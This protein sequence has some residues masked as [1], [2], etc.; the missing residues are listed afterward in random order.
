MSVIEVKDLYWRYPAFT[1]EMNPWALKGANLKVEEGEF[2]GIT[3]PSGAGK[4]TLC[5]MIS[6]VMPHDMKL[7][8]RI[9]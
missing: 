2:L 1:G 5:Y 3:G 4:T 6:G 7:I 8:L 9:E